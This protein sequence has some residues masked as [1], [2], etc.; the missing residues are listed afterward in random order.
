MVAGFWYLIVV[1][2]ASFGQMGL[3]RRFGRGYANTARR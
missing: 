1:S 3:E 2:I